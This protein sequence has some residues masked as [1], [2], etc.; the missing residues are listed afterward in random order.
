MT[1][2]G[3]TRQGVSC[4]LVAPTEETYRAVRTI[5]GMETGHPPGGFRKIGRPAEHEGERVVDV[6]VADLVGELKIL[7]K[8]RGIAAI[9]LGERT[10]S[11]VR[12]VCRISTEDDP[13]E[14]RRKI[15]G[16]L[17]ELAAKL[18][19]DLR[20]AVLAAF[21]LHKDAQNPFY[22]D[23]VHWLAQALDRDDRTV[24]R[25]I[26]E[27]IARLAELAIVP[28]PGNPVVRDQRWHTEELRVALAMDRPVPETFV[29]RRIIADVD[30]VSEV[31]LPQVQ[32]TADVDVFHG[33]TLAG[34]A[35][36][37]P[38]ALRRGER[39]D[40]A[41]RV[42]AQLRRPRYVCVPR[43]PCDLF[44]L[45]LRFGRERPEEVALIEKIV[46]PDDSA[47]PGRRVPLDRAGEVHVRF[48]HLTPGFAY[49]VSWAPPAA[50]PA[51]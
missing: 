5:T 33:G 35:I 39:H 27:G 44:D 13:A 23:R 49:G 22:Q 16:R 2:R 4:F 15:S 9:R 29:L 17:T 34:Q 1:G 14:I 31:D 12:T 30:G 8:G 11:A 6:S 24:R 47:T 28:A 7:R 19:R 10:G 26:D 42:R 51:P 48:R 37:L 43:Q 36:E 38:D 45:H 18:P 3:N 41:L 50:S 46:I 32:A 25:R 40:I 20:T 21:G